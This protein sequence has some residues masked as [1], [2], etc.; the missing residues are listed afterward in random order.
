MPE[1]E[2]TDGVAQEFALEPQEQAVSPAG[3]Y[4]ETPPAG[5]QPLQQRG[6][7][8]LEAT[9]AVTRAGTGAQSFVRRNAHSRVQRIRM[10]LAIAAEYNLECLQLDYNTASVVMRSLTILYGFRQSPTTCWNTIGKHL[11]EIGFK[12]LKSDPCVCTYSQ[13]GAIYILTLYVDEVLL[14]GK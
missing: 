14:L 12:S 5:S 3:A 11:V 1:G 7:S 4:L 8:R 2:P 6:H 9:P 13:S 10:M